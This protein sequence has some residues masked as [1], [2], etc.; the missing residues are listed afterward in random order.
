[1]RKN[2]STPLQ[3]RQLHKPC[4]RA[5]AQADRRRQIDELDLVG[6]VKDAVRQRSRWRIPVIWQPGRSGFRVVDVDRRP[7]SDAGFQQP[8]ISCQRLNGRQRLPDQDPESLA[9]ESAA[10]ESRI[11][12]ELVGAGCHDI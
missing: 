2:R 4:R 6:L 9:H 12:I 1:V 5:T 7:H 10:C 11:E 3:P 8:S